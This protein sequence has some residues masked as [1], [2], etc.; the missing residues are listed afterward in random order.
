MA[1]DSYNDLTIFHR[2]LNE[3]TTFIQGIVQKESISIVLACQVFEEH[4]KNAD[5]QPFESDVERLLW[6][7]LRGRNLAIAYL[8]HKRHEDQKEK[9][10]RAAIHDCP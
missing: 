8:E 10:I 3:I 4:K 7:R 2:Y 6:L 1:T 9:A 5:A